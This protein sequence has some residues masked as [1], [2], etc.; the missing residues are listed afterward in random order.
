MR[1]AGK[2]PALFFEEADEYT[3]YLM[4]NILSVRLVNHI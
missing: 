2:S 1:F 4:S 3:S